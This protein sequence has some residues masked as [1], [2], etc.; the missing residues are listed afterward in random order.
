MVDSGALNQRTGTILGGSRG[1]GLTVR[2]T[3]CAKGPRSGAAACDD[4]GD[5]LAQLGGE[6]PVAGSHVERGSCGVGESIDDV[7]VVV[8]VVVDVGVPTCDGGHPDMISVRTAPAP[9][10]DC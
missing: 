10:R 1:R 6:Q 7:V 5:S 3:A 2:A 8:V 4:V 9:C